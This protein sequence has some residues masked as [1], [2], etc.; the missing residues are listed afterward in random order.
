[1]SSKVLELQKELAISID[2]DEFIDIVFMLYDK[3]YIIGKL[4][5][6]FN[7]ILLFKSIHPYDLS[8]VKTEDTEVILTDELMKTFLFN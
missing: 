8:I 3:Q 1:M 6:L 2:D 4:P 5:L 7:T